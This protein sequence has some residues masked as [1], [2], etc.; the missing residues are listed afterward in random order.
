MVGDHEGFDRMR[1]RA[2]KVSQ[3]D[4]SQEIAELVAVTIDPSTATGGDLD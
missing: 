4:S 1:G 3:K 2:E